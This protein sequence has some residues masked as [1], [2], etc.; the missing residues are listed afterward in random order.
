[1]SFSGDGAP[2]AGCA[3]VLYG[4]ANPNSAASA[5]P[6][7]TTALSIAQDSTN[8]GR[9]IDGAVADTHLGRSL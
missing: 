2:S 1:M 3:Y 4:V 9:I 5:W 7:D 8:K 6:T